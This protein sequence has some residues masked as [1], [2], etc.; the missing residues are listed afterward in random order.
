LSDV[1]S[2]KGMFGQSTS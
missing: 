1:V 2:Q